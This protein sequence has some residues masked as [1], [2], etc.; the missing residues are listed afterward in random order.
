[1]KPLSKPT[2]IVV[3]AKEPRPDEVKTRLIPALGAVG[4]ARLAEKMLYYTLDQ[5]QVAC[6]L[7]P[8]LSA[9]LCV[10]PVVTSAFWQPYQKL[11]WLSMAGQG[12]GD[13]GQRLDKA[14]Q[15]IG[16]SGNNLVFI[17]TDC[18]GLTATYLLNAAAMLENHEAVISPTVDGGYALLGLTEYQPAVFNGISWSTDQVFVQTQAKLSANS[19]VL[20]CLHDIDNPEDLPHLPQSWRD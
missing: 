1:M 3:F 8:L 18:P 5:V 15:Q 20:P 2:T 7:Q 9:Q 6:K 11:S 19:A 17:G 14:A 16:A 13:L 4:A 12:E 10:A